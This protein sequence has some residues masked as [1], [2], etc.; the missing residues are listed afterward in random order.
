VYLHVTR[1]ETQ[2]PGSSADAK[3]GLSALK[4][5]AN[6]S[7]AR[8]ARVEIG[9]ELGKGLSGQ[10]A[11]AGAGAALGVARSPP[12]TPA[13]GSAMLRKSVEREWKHL[14]AGRARPN[15]Q[16]VH[17]AV[18]R[19]GSFTIKNLEIRSG[20]TGSGQALPVSGD[21]A[22]QRSAAEPEASV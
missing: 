19:L 3:I 12:R 17:V 5:R 18:L 11:L 15:S 7:W 10:R 16:S 1:F 9:L 14:T 20:I 6:A 21:A 13:T 4:E 2:P 8:R 22:G